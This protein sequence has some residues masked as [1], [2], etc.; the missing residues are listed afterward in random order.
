VQP[1]RLNSPHLLFPRSIGRVAQ[2]F[3]IK[4][5]CS[6]KSVSFCAERREPQIQERE[7]W[8]QQRRLES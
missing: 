1:T 8:E 4:M 3:A 2:M 5:H 6:L 7:A